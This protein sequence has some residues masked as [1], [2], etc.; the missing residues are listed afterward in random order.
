MNLFMTIYTGHAQ[1]YKIQKR[2]RVELMNEYM[3]SVICYFIIIFTDFMN[4]TEQYE[5]SFIIIGLVMVFFFVNMAAVSKGLIKSLCLILI[6]FYLKVA[7]TM[8]KV[9]QAIVRFLS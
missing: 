1:P 2:N 8:K 7:R 4:V 3:F 9:N 5:K 6:R